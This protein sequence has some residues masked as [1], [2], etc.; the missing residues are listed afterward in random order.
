MNRNGL[1]FKKT[2]AMQIA[3]TKWIDQD[4]ILNFT[5]NYIKLLQN[6]CVVHSQLGIIL[7][8]NHFGILGIR[9]VH[10]H[11]YNKPSFRKC[12]AVTDYITFDCW[13]NPLSHLVS[14]IWLELKIY[15]INILRS[16]TSVII[17]FYWI[18]NKE[19]F[20]WDRLYLM[21]TTARHWCFSC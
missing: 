4:A 6:S 14:D 1:S 10:I 19:R 5:L 21:Y 12:F 18:I 8:N 9:I 7:L 13:S 15:E 20:Q 16:D 2:W 17:V 11:M 3:F